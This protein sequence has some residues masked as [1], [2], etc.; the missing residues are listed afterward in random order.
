M[1]VV[2]ALYLSCQQRVG[3]LLKLH[4]LAILRFRRILHYTVQSSNAIV[5][6]ITVLNWSNMWCIYFFYIEQTKVT[7]M[8]LIFLQM[9]LVKLLNQRPI[10]LFGIRISVILNFKVVC[11]FQ[12][13]LCHISAISP[14]PTTDKS[15]RLYYLIVMLSYLQ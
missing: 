12:Y 11:N 13:L 15:W 8:H 10:Y 3:V 14:Y 7:D 6:I 1:R 5:V 4:W 2:C 9:F